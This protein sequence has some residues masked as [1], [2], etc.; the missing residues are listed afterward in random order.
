MATKESMMRAA[1]IE[2][3]LQL[4]SKEGLKG[5]S[6]PESK[7]EDKAEGSEAE[8]GCEAEGDEALLVVATPEPEDESDKAKRLKKMKAMK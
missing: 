8:E 3:L 4:I 7:A 6:E 5:L 2:Q 1:V